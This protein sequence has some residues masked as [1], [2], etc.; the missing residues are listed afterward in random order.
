MRRLSVAFNEGKET[1][2]S[3]ILEAITPIVTAIVEKV[4][5]A[6]EKFIGG[7][8]GADGLKGAFNDFVE[9]W[10]KILVPVFQGVELAFNTIKDAVLRNKDEFKALFD[11]LKNY[12]APFLGGA[13]KL[14]FEGIGTAI[15]LVVD[16]IGAFIGAIEKA[17]GWWQKLVDLLK[18]NRI[19]KMFGNASF[20]S[21]GDTSGNIV[22]AGLFAGGISDTGT[23]FGSTDLRRQLF[24]MTPEQQAEYER[25]KA[26]TARI[27]EK[28]AARARGEIFGSGGQINNITVNG[29]LD[30]ES[31]ARQIVTLL[32]DLYYRGTGGA[33]GLVY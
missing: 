19:T 25:T 8:G 5:P 14:A 9:F 3:F 26:E 21:G 11:F 2:G 24:G 7:I 15:G 12:V 18:K 17:Y 22:G 16:G 4:V 1:I 10:K 29:A 6:V 33:T 23:S 32:N 27:R 20:T 13:L 30:F 28:I 31:T